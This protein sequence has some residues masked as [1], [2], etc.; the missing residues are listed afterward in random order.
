MDLKTGTGFVSGPL[1]NAG[2]NIGNTSIKLL[3]TD[4]YRPRGK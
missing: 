3:V 4:I 2:K 1:S